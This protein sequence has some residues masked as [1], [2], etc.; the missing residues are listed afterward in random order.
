MV[1]GE[2]CAI[3]L[4][5][6]I[7]ISSSLSKTIDEEFLFRDFSLDMLNKREEIVER[8]QA[9]TMISI[10]TFHKGKRRLWQL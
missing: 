4:I 8:N 6:G 9:I 2:V 1:T 5:K 10:T 3:F 7:C